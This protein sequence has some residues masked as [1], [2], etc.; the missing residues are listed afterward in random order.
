MLSENLHPCLC[1]VHTKWEKKLEESL[2]CIE[3]LWKIK[4]H[5][6]RVIQIQLFAIEMI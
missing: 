3:M 2:N 5:G 6:L 1:S 4:V